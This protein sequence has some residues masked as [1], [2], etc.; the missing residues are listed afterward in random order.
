MKKAVVSWSGGKDSYFAAIKAMQQGFEPVVLLNVLNEEG[1]YS[2]SHRIPKKIL[3]RQAQLFQKPIQLITASWQDY[4]SNFTKALHELKE[5]YNLEQA[6]FGDI[7]L[8]PHRD[9]EEMVCRN[10]GLEAVLPLWQQNR[11]TLVLEML[12]AG[13]RTMIVSCNETMGERF[14]GK[15]LDAALVSELETMNIDPCGENGEFH[16]L[17]TYGPLFQKPMP[18]RVTAT[19]NHDHYWFAEIKLED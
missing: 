14:L 10:A 12:Q 3:E 17:V 9:W 5:K 4:E 16:T 19:H 7:D 11:K 18:V 1:A 15:Y 8:Q 13:I 6:V 2:R